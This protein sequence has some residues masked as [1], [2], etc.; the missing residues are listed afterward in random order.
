MKNK[1]EEI[2]T[3]VESFNISSE[4]QEELKEMVIKYKD[5][6]KIVEKEKKEL[7]KSFEEL[8]EKYKKLKG[9]LISL[10]DN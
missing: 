10:V 2:Q 7:E 1:N 3:K 8:N 5:D 6:I 4:Y 9:K